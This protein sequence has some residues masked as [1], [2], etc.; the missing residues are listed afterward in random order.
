MSSIAKH[1]LSTLRTARGSSS[2][3]TMPIAS[4]RAFSATSRSF[5][6]QPAKGSSL[7]SSL[8][9]G[10]PQARAEGE[11]QVIQHS[12]LIGRNKYVHE[13][14]VH[15]VK[16][17]SVEQYKQ[18]AEKYFTGLASDPSLK[19]KLTGSW[20]TLIGDV[21]NFVHIL[22][23]ENYAGYDS[24]LAKWQQ[25]PELPA[26]LH[27]QILP[28]L[29]SRH[30]QLMSEFAFWPSS[31]PHKQGGIFEMRS[32]E[33]VPGTLLEW[34]TAWKRGLEARRRFVQPA[35]AWFAQV[36]QLHEVHHLWQYPNMAERKMTREQA[37]N[38][39]GWSE[40]VQQTVKLAKSMK[41]A[42]LVPCPW[43]PLQ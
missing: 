12:K 24:S 21:D 19:V 30:S 36:G 3:R 34:E 9:H 25:H 8:L 7:L 11:T 15:R 10:D 43:S 16:P 4:L 6:D 29:H 22:E 23:Y 32:Y 42:I 41:C 5:K 17:D 38:V 26:I 28:T 18:A 40:T 20:Q 35:G 27:K 37:W 2:L 1:T 39:G 33:L 31:P 14:I 13:K